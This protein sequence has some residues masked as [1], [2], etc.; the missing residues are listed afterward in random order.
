MYLG[1]MTNAFSGHPKAA[2]ELADRAIQLS[3]FDLL[4]YQAHFARGFA[5]MQERRFADAAVQF[6]KALEANPHL[7]SI[8]FCTAIA[9]AMAGR[10]E[11]ARTLAHR[12][13]Q[14]EPGFRLRLFGELMVR[15]IADAFAEGG[16]LL[17]LQE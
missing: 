10:I 9:L 15:E 2:E 3:P 7:S 16:R 8:Y 17:N 1:A 14:L 5:G 4:T 6:Q 13:L 11:A 12:G